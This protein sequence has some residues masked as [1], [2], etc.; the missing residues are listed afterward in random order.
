MTG[1]ELMGSAPVGTAIIRLA[2]PM[3][4]AMLAQ[5]IFQITDMYFIGQTGN[6]NMVAAVALASPLYM[7]SQALGNI[8]AT[9][10]STYISRMLG[11]KNEGVA[12]N[13]SAV[14][15]YIALSLGAV[16]CIILM[17]FKTPLLWLIGASEA[18]FE[19]TNNYFSVIAFAI[20]MA[21]AGGVMSG[22][23]RSEGETQ[24][25][26]TQQLVGIVT[27]II[28]DPILILWAGW[29][30][31][32]AGLATVAATI[33]SFS[34]GIRYFLKRS[35]TLS[36]LPSDFKPNKDMMGQILAIGVPAGAA[37]IIMTFSNIL[38]NR[39][40]SS[41]G[42]FVIAG[43]AVQMRVGGLFFMLI[44]AIVMGYQPFAGFNYGAKQ[45]DRLRK[46]FKFTILFATGLC[47]LA[48]FALQLVGEHLIRFF[49]NHD[50]TIEYGVRILKVFLWGVPFM[51]AQ[52][53]M[54]VSFQALGKPLQSTIV[55]MGRSL[56]FYLPLLLVLNHFFGFDGFI[57][58]QP[59]SDILT[60][61][62]AVVLGFS[63]IKI[64]RGLGSPAAGPAMGGPGGP[65]G[66]PPDGAPP[67]PLAGPPEG[68][69]EG[70]PTG[71]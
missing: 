19:P 29:G 49:V 35:A 26:M 34:Y 4:V 16:L 41:H 30:T 54:M 28:L 68:P 71:P 5:S 9:G 33:V 12:K 51:G 42:D 70:P 39:I 46:G 69:S 50:E 11:A 40:A 37:N 57:W 58:A 27:N 67:S 13:A 14:S 22:V 31:T 65:P 10:G 53:T 52:I 56:L 59:I 38:V 18:T 45:Y 48:F 17:I 61:G 23:M 15:F 21:A 20:P 64:M 1:V 3:M 60:T 6:P 47:V 63:L 25:A 36:I 7:I 32:G 66:L 24:K 8:F 43:N 44:M 2:L 62:I 55:I